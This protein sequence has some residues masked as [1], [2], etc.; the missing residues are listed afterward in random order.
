[1]SSPHFSSLGNQPPVEVSLFA[2]ALA[3]LAPLGDGEEGES[4]CPNDSL[5]P[6]CYVQQCKANKPTVTGHC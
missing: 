5:P 6:A 1:M 2:L 4:H 3:M